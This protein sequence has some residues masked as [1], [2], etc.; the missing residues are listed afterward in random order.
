MLLE[1]GAIGVL[2]ILSPATDGT[3]RDDK[4]MLLELDVELEAAGVLSEPEI[5]AGAVGVLGTA[6]LELVLGAGT[7]GPF[8]SDSRLE[9][10]AVETDV[11]IEPGLELDAGVEVGTETVEKILPNPGLDAGTV[12]TIALRLELGAVPETVEEILKLDSKV[13]TETTGV[14]LSEEALAVGTVG[15]LLL[16]ELDAEPVGVVFSELEVSVAD[17]GTKMEEEFSLDPGA[18]DDGTNPGD[19][20]TTEVDRVSVAVS[21]HMEVV[22]V[23]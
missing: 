23:T 12:E 3:A 2:G 6:L 8:L 5:W 1:P 15:T 19:A 7:V 16:G 14:L 22:M 10:G 18:T 20:G 13:G 17:D 9:V 21:E 11:L 4:D